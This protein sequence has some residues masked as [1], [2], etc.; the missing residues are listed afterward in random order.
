ME[1]ITSFTVDHMTLLPGLYV[2]RM[3]TMDGF[4]FTTFDLRVTRPNFEPVMNTA[5]IHTIEHL[6]ATYF[7]NYHK[8]KTMYFGPMGCRT[9]FYLIYKGELTADDVKKDVIDCFRFIRDFEG[10]IPGAKPEECGNY[11]D[12]NL[13]MAKYLAKKYLKALGD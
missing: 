6:A 12:Q 4:K 8:D 2:S 13:P 7:R 11:L 1:K 9:G 10:E 5:E 3:D